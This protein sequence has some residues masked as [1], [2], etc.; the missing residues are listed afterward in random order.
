MREKHNAYEDYM[1]A[2]QP[3]NQPTR[4]RLKG[5]DTVIRFEEGL[6]GFSQFKDFVLMENERL[7]PF[8]LLQSLELPSI[9]FLVLEASA[10]VYNY[11][12]LVPV[13][14]WESIGVVGATKPL[15]F[16]IVVIGLSP[17]AS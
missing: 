3:L 9:S 14:E 17:E 7:A 4:L 5:K 15:V 10:L 1:K 2:V 11:H 12:E 6:I 8:W 13:R 16:V